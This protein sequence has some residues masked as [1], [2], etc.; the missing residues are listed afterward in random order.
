MRLMGSFVGRGAQPR[1][2]FL[3]VAAFAGG[4]GKEVVF[5]SACRGLSSALGVVCVTVRWVRMGAERGG[6]P[7]SAHWWL[8]GGGAVLW[9]SL[10][11]T[12]VP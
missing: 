4:G 8:H 10:S 3:Y 5:M 9:G 11:V 6:D 1:C 7:C 2:F 12:P